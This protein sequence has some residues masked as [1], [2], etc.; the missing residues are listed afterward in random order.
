MPGIKRGAAHITGGVTGYVQSYSIDVNTDTEEAT[1]SIGN[2]VARSHFNGTRDITF[3]FIT[4]A[5]A[6]ETVGATITVTC[7]T[8]VADAA[9]I[10]GIYDVV[11]M[12]IKGTNRG[13][14]T[15]TLT[16]KRW[17]ANGIPA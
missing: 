13:Y 9:I 1:D 2:V 5:T 15:G 17:T 4:G 8:S 3:D 16:G 7:A 10:S 6:Q 11:K 14:Q 12:S